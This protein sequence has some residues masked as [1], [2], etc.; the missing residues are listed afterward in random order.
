MMEK[1]VMTRIHMQDQIQNRI[2]ELMD[3]KNSFD[4]NA[5]FQHLIALY[6]IFL[7]MTIGLSW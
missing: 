2:E 6:F 5:L 1:T 4:W 7:F 3:E